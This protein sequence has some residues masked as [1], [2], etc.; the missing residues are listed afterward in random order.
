MP[1]RRVD[2]L[3]VAAAVVAPSGDT[4]TQ[5]W[6]CIGGLVDWTPDGWLIDS[7]LTR[8]VRRPLDGSG[9]L[10]SQQKAAVVEGPGGTGFAVP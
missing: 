7:M 6:L 5:R 2:P 9:T 1:G 8:E 10:T 3:T 4:S